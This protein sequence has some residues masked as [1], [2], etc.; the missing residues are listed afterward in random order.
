MKNL[1]GEPLQHT[2]HLRKL[3][4]NPSG[5][6]L[7]QHVRT[8]NL[9]FDVRNRRVATCSNLNSVFKPKRSIGN[10]HRLRPRTRTRARTHTL[11]P[12]FVRLQ[13][14][15]NLMQLLDELYHSPNNRRLIS[16]KKNN[17][18]T[19]ITSHHQK[20]IKITLTREKREI[21]RDPL[22]VETR[23]ERSQNPKMFIH[24]PPPVSLHS[25]VSHGVVDVLGGKE[26]IVEKYLYKCLQ[27]REGKGKLV[28]FGVYNKCKML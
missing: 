15:Q 9:R 10:C 19:H 13:R 14:L 24:L 11:P 18:H 1:K 20:H 26:K 25:N 22:D 3:P 28:R 7:Q 23:G 27:E 8:R 2:N 21:E 16:L 6:D 5:N 12:P 17:H 4:G